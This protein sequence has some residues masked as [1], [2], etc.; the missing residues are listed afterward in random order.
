MCVFKGAQLAEGKN[1]ERIVELLEKRWRDGNRGK[2]VGVS[3]NCVK[4]NLRLAFGGW[5]LFQTDC[6]GNSGVAGVQPSVKWNLMLR[7]T[8]MCCVSDSPVC[9]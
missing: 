3:E 5:G 8:L 7:G 4:G 2:S 6:T 1:S 9:P